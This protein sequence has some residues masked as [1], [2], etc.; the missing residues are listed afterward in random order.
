[1]IA[2]QIPYIYDE[3]QRRILHFSCCLTIPSTAQHIHSTDLADEVEALQNVI[4]GADG[5]ADGVADGADGEQS[6]RA[7][8]FIDELEKGPFIAALGSVAK[9]HVAYR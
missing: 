8:K 7:G 4:D 1:M 3:A 2:Y 5:V 6:G 9:H